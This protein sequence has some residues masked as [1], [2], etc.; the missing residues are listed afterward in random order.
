VLTF[1]AWDARSYANVGA[2]QGQYYG[3]MTIHSPWQ[4]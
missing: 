3:N 2:L 1:N 4:Y